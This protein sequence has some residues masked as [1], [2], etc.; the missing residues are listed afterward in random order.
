MVE[1]LTALAIGFSGAIIGGTISGIIEHWL[2]TE[3]RE[4][5]VRWRVGPRRIMAEVRADWRS[6]SD[7]DSP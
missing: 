5:H 2:G 7:H 6:G 1:G 3:P 4:P